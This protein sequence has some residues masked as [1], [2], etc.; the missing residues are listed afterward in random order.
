MFM[1]LSDLLFCKTQTK[2]ENTQISEKGNNY[3]TYLAKHITR[4][5]NKK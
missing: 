5:H 4:K 3:F 1:L 2:M